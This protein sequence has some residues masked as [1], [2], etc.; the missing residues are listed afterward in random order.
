M[1]LA[2]NADKEEA[3]RKFKETH[4]GFYTDHIEGDFKFPKSR[5][6]RDAWTLVGNKIVVDKQKAKENIKNRQPELTLESLL[7]EINKL[8]EKL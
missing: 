1:E 4:E 8:K 7:E 5:E 6:D 3:I 2:P